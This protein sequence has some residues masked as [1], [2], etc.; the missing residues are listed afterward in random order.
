MDVLLLSRIQ[1]AFTIA[2]HY[3]YPPLSIG[4]GVTLVIMEGLW[5]K[6]NNPIYH[7][8]ARFWTRVF[9]LTF[10]IGVAT[11]IVMEF[12]FG[13]NWATYS[14]YVGDVFGSALAAEGIFAFFL[15]SG[16][17]AIL[18]F[19]WDK[20][21]RKLHY[22]ATW[23]VCLGAH[24]S[25]VWIVVANS[26][27]Q[28]PA[29]FHVVGEGLDARAEI[30]DFWAMVFNPSAMDRL[31]HTLCGAWQAGAFLVVSVSA[32][33]LLRRKH[34][35]FAQRS[36]KV[37]LA[38]GLVASLLQLV[39]GHDSA[40]G[41]SRHQPIKM[42]AFEGQYESLTNAPL[43]LFGWVNES[44]ERTYSLEVPGLLSYLLHGDTAAEVKGLRELAPDPAD[45]PPVNLTFQFYHV[46]IAIGFGM[47]AVSLTAAVFWWRDRLFQTRWLL[48]LLVF[49][50]LGPQ[51]ANQFGWYA[52]E[53]GRQ[54]WIVYDLLRT[55]EGISRVVQAEAVLGSLILFALIYLLLFAVF[56][57]LLNDKI[58]HGPD[59]SDLKPTGK[60]SPRPE[61]SA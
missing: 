3:I 23:M 4:L 19:G 22:F 5:L 31:S 14:R 24:F 48:W 44:E 56:V 45:R 15:E 57:Y 21:G 60:L 2:F 28:T 54:P 49:S 42:A 55:S 32:F 59:P 41:V 16:F 9:A 17:L 25:A 10:A 46:M 51:L 52:A 30:T 26:W 33:Y 34:L 35:D 29:G 11:G 1:F 12:E 36:L 38:V 39:T 47:I 43:T 53:V 18:L 40:V 8:M 7:Q 13:T 37:G 50:V 27:M 20:V 58:Q 61:P 6:T